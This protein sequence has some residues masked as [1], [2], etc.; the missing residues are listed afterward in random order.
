MLRKPS[1]VTAFVTG[2]LVLYYVLFHSGAHPDII[3][4]MFL[5]APFLMA[6][7]VI[8]IWKGTDE[9]YRVAYKDLAEPYGMPVELVWRDVRDG[10]TV[11]T[12]RPV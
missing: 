6:W 4:A 3:T 1:F 9:K 10:V 7:L 2:W 11:P 12:W 8:T 5:A